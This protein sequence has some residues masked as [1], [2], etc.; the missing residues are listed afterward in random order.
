MSKILSVAF[1]GEKGAFSEMAA[2]NFFKQSAK[3][4]PFN[5]FESVF[6]A[7]KKS[8]CKY[9]IVPI[10]NSLAGSVHQNYDLLLKYNLKI[11]GE[12]QIPIQHNL[13]GH[14][15]IPM[16]YIREIHSHPQ[17]LAQCSIFLNKLNKIKI[18]PAYDTAGAVKEIKEKGLLHAA[19][20]AGRMAA[21]IH[22]MKI[23]KTGIENIKRNYT[24]FLILSRTEKQ[25]NGFKP[26]T[27]IVFSLKNRPGALYEGLA[28]F[29]RQKIDLLKIESRPQ[30][31]STWCYL[32]YLDF[33]GHY[34]DDACR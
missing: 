19:A 26:K 16:H 30:P 2:L 28:F 13:I 15:D 32:F 17:A 4:R 31:E 3:P 25:L 21:T 7:V 24:R 5:D 9:G 34:K 10:E 1:Q 20:I 27:S 23:L 8:H 18:I 14:P 22:K 12:T 29:A 11:I 33:F 6:K